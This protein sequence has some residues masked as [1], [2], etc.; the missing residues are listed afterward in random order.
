MINSSNKKIRISVRVS[1][2]E[3]NII[4]KRA[5]L[6]NEKSLSSYLRKMAISGVIVNVN[7]SEFADLKREL[8]AVGANVNQIARRI[9]STNRFY[10][11]DVEYIKEV[12][13]KIWQSLN[14]V[15]SKLRSL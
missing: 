9:N 7:I 3:L 2:D 14:S 5:L 12:N 1:E 8:T 15:Q 10:D 11:D 6:T 4:E 13:E